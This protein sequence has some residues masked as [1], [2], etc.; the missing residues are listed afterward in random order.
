M[1]DLGGFEWDPDKNIANLR[2]HGVDFLGAARVF[3][4]PIRLDRRD[5]AHSKHEERRITIGYSDPKI[6]TV[7]YT[8]RLDDVIRIISARKA[9][10]D[11]QKAYDKG[12]FGS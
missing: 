9:S 4:D 6:L 11:E 10:K 8:E 5:T 3:A 7:V 1:L 12:H 2:K